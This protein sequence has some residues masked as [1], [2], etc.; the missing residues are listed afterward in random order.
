MKKPAW[1]L[2][3]LISLPLL[4]AEP[5]DKE[6][7]SYRDVPFGTSRNETRKLLKMRAEDCSRRDR[8]IDP[9]GMSCHSLEEFAVGNAKVSNT[10]I[11]SEDRF[12]SA[13]MHIKSSDYG[14]IREVF[15]SK[16]G[17]PTSRS[18][19][20]VTT[21]M[22]AVYENE[23]LTWVGKKLTV[24]LDRFVSNVDSSMAMFT[25]NEY[26]EARTKRYTEAKEKAKKAF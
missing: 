19:T 5:W 3:I 21:K 11:F 24:S 22:G 1:M 15:L 12:V 25:M 17:S 13:A 7:D 10:L 26:A 18:T 14:S 9:N 8:E 23:T 16:F 20:P 2:A 6:P 4:G